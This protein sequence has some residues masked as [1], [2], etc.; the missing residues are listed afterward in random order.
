[1]ALGAAYVEVH[2][3]TRPFAKEISKELKAILEATEKL[4]TPQSERIGDH[5]A[6][7]IG[8]GINRNKHKI[9]NSIREG[10]NV[11][12][13]TGG[14]LASIKRTFARLGEEAAVFFAKGFGNAIQAGGNLLA[15][16]LETG[17]KTAGNLLGSIFNVSTS[18][19]AGSAAMV[20]LFAF[21]GA[22]VLPTLI[23]ACIAL[24]GALSNL[25]G[26]LLIIP[27]A[28]G[29]ILAVILPLVAAFHGFAGA[30]SAVISKDPKKIAEAMKGLTPAARGVVKEFQK[31]MPFFS[32]LSDIAQ[33]AF[34]KPL[35]GG[36][37]KLINRAS[38]PLLVGF[39]NVAAAAGSLVGGILD[40]LSRPEMAVFFD[41][42][43]SAAA[44]A[45]MT[46]REPLI[47]LVTAFANMAQAAMPAFQTLIERLGGFLTS[48]ADWINRSIE[49]GAFQAFLD[50]ALS[51]LTDVWNLIK[52]VIGLFAVLFA[53]T[54][55]G[56]RTFLQLV[57]D[58]V[59]KLT[60]FFES[61]KGQR[62]LL[63]M[64]DLAIL[65]GVYM[66]AL[67][68][69]LRLLANQ[70]EIIA[71]ILRSIIRLISG[72]DIRKLGEAKAIGGALNGYVGY[73]SGGIITSPQLA[74]VGE[75]GAPEVIIPLNNP[76][77]AQQ[78][79]DQSG[80]SSMIGGQGNVT[81]IA[82]IGGEQVE[83]YVEKRIDSAFTNQSR[84]LAYGA[85]TGI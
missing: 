2:A 8:N 75:G 32:K 23:S 3:D 80:L 56:G 72:I 48:F 82:Y 78:L 6:T 73:A 74:M 12:E 59:N 65:F 77:R 25:L 61:E 71:S 36:L 79:A 5:L 76:Q 55:A 22:V 70:L 58:A 10:L 24:L 66:T 44:T 69:I 47:S 83:A 35:A 20:A 62:A 85:R 16:G 11:V 14:F 27:S 63:A 19:L 26:L 9:R 45:L 53:G 81:L 46:L 37:T 21:F 60:A 64:I 49:N 51:T 67:Y 68:P 38:L 15:A 40:A 7:G 43:F 57:T 30:I 29:V 13:E 17:V 52:A 33:E 28:L 54:E 1:M 42:L 39:K 18:S 34:F 41:S 4:I 50:K 84:A 31:L